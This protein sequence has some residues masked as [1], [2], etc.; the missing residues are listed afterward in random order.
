M[1]NHRHAIARFEYEKDGVFVEV[2]REDYNYFVEAAGMGPGPFAFRVTD[3]Y[4]GSV[5]DSGIPLGDATTAQGSGEL[6]ECDQ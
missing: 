4:G 1:R 2:P 5:T 6:P 3:V